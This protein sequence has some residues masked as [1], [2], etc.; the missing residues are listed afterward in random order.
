MFRTLLFRWLRS[1]LL[2]GWSAL[3]C[4]IAMIAL[5]TVARA[6]MNGTVT[7]CEFT[8]YLPFVLLSAILIGW[9]QASAVAL[10]SVA[11]LGGLFITPPVSQ[12][13]KSCFLAG[14]GIFMAASAAMI[15]TAILVRRAFAGL[16]SRGADEAGGGIVFSVEQGEV[17]ASWYGQGAPVRLGAERKVAE[18]MRHFLAHSPE[19]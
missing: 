4:A 13:E 14:A 9:W 12:L 10:I 15:A 18:T 3:I 16:Q 6:A 11:I 5:P 8:P 7:G 17:W 19:N 1:P 2:T